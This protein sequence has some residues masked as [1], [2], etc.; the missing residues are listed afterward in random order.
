MNNRF[1]LILVGAL[2]ALLLILALPALAQG[3]VTVWATG[4]IRLRAAPDTAAQVLTTIPFGAEL[5]AVALNNDGT[6]AQ[7]TF[8]NQTGWAARRYLRGSLDVLGGAVVAAGS[9]PASQPSL[10]ASEE[11]NRVLVLVNQARAAAGLRP[12]TLNAA[13]TA[14]SERHANDMA[15]GNF[16]S[17]TGS[18]GSDPARRVTDA[19]Y[20][21]CIVG[22]NAAQRWDVSAQ[23]VFDQ[24]INSPP[25]RENLLR[26]EFAEMGLA[27]AIASDGAVY[28][29]MEMGG[30]R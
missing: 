26:P 25:H 18:D 23:G 30:R 24:W 15:A 28:Y 5:T 17:H 6:W 10:P 12:L 11:A 2:L 14:A 16:L 3:G 13:L 20:N 22:E 1:R 19:G 7:V 27:Y 21:W 4:N 9:V 8:N 29:A